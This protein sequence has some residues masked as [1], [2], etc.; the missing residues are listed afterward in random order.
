MNTELIHGQNLTANA[1]ITKLVDSGVDDFDLGAASALY[2]LL[3]SISQE[4]QITLKEAKKKMVA[5]LNEVA[6]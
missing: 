5:L 4:R 2:L 3:N 6:K 1:V